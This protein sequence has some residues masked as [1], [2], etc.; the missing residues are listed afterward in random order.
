M[1]RLQAVKYKY[2]LSPQVQAD[3]ATLLSLLE[4]ESAHRPPLLLALENWS[5]SVYVADTSKTPGINI[6]LE[7]QLLRNT[8]S[9]TRQGAKLFEEVSTHQT[10]KSYH[11]T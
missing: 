3:G 10:A 8:L 2:L 11:I 1:F 6:I 4:M 7:F 5:A 9:K